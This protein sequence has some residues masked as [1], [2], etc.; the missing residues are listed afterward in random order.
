LRNINQHKK[1]ENKDLGLFNETIE[2]K[3]VATVNQTIKTQNLEPF[4][5]TAQFKDFSSLIQ[6]IQS[7][8]LSEYFGHHSNKNDQGK[9]HFYTFVNSAILNNIYT[10]CLIGKRLV[11]A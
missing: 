7:K 1:P 5:Q 10:P 8:N 6:K 2:S 9:K 11:I 3:I 4:N